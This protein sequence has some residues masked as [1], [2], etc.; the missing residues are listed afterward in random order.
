MVQSASFRSITLTRRFGAAP[1]LIFSSRLMRDID[2]A[3]KSSPLTCT[4]SETE[5]SKMIVI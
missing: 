4:K 1:M 2:P 3:H 5:P